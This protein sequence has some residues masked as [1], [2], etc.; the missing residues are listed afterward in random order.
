VPGDDADV[1]GLAS[2]DRS[3]LATALHEHLAATERLPI[4]PTANR[5][6]GEAQAAAA[7]A[8]GGDVPPAV[9]TKR[10]RQVVRLLESAGDTDHPEADRRVAAAFKIARELCER[11]DD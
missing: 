9:V 1:D 7:D 4:D 6:L 8:A 10:A 2:M 3:E 5:W 11:G